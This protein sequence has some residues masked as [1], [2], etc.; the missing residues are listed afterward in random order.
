AT[1]K[2]SEQALRQAFDLSDTALIDMGDFAGGLL[3]YLRRHPVPSLVIAGGF[4]KMT[5]LAQGFLDLHSGRSAV[6][7][8]WL[9]SRLE[10]LGA[11][12]EVLARTADA[13]T[14]Y[15]VLQIVGAL[16]PQLADEV[17]M[18]ARA[19]ALGVLANAPVCVTVLVVDRQSNII[20]RAN[21]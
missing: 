7:F 12:R 11:D 21:G 6:D 18:A 19:T 10:R 3:K 9:A 4:A 20:A 2:T 14:A 16:A 5:K 17:A 1:G 13:N 8:T 15:E